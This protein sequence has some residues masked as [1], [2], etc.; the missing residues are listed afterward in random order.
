MPAKSAMSANGRL[1]GALQRDRI[2]ALMVHASMPAPFHRMQCTSLTTGHTMRQN[3]SRQQALKTVQC[4]STRAAAPCAA[5]CGSQP[6]SPVLPLYSGS[7]APL[8]YACKQDQAMTPMPHGPCTCWARCSWRCCVNIMTSQDAEMHS[9]GVCPCDAALG[10]CSRKLE[11]ML[12]ASC[13]LH[14]W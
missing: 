10:S 6:L 8:S 9:L 3:D 5:G 12:T 11:S 7:G 2:Q 14:R 1:A 4:S 13:P